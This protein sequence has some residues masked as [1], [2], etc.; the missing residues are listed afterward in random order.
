L[1]IPAREKDLPYL[2]ALIR[3]GAKEKSF[4]EELAGESPESEL[5]FANFG[6]VLAR[7]VWSRPASLGQPRHAPAHVF[8]YQP[9]AISVPIGFVAVRGIGRLGDELWLAAIDRD[10]RGRGIGRRMLVDFFATGDGKRTT[11]AQCRIDAPGAQ[12]CA[13]VLSTIG[14]I[15]ARVGNDAVWMARADLPS[16]ALDWMR[17]APLLKRASA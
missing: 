9:T 6:E 3:D 13:H 1:F 8:L 2:R 17:T 15:T 4:D 5:F 14:F 11:V 16:S 12:A 10:I 7:K